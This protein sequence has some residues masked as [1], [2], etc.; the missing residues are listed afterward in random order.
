MRR[1][2]IVSDSVLLILGD[3]QLR[4]SR[5]DFITRAFSNRMDLLRESFGH[6]SLH[7]AFRP[8]ADLLFSLHRSP[9]EITP[10]DA[11]S[12]PFLGLEILFVT[13]I[14]VQSGLHLERNINAG[15]AQ[16]AHLVRIT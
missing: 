7:F 12:P 4:R 9:L 16:L 10:G 1:I 8:S 3:A 15:L 14:D 6:G 11:R 5:A 2:R 13:R